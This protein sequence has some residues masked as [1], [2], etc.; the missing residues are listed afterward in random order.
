MFNA[1]DHVLNSGLL[2]LI[3]Q[4]K[5]D[6]TRLMGTSSI[7]DSNNLKALDEDDSLGET[8]ILYPH[9]TGEYFLLNFVK[10]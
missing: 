4:S 7:Y 8:D 6:M 5:D 2:I 9:L 1:M 3:W 10:C